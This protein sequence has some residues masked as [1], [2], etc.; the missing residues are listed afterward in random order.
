MNSIVSTISFYQ[1]IFNEYPEIIFPTNSSK[2]IIDEN[3]IDMR[4]LFKSINIKLKYV[5]SDEQC[6]FFKAVNT[7][8]RKK[9]FMVRV[10]IYTND[11]NDLLKSIIHKIK[12]LELFN[13]LVINK[14]TPHLPLLIA[15]FNTSIKNF[16]DLSDNKNKS[17]ENF[18]EKYH[19][20][21]YENIVTVCMDE[22]YDYNLLD[23]INDKCDS[24]SL[25]EWSVIFFQILHTLAIIHISYPNFMHGNLDVKNIWIQKIDSDKKSGTHYKYYINNSSFD[26]PNISLR[27]KICEL[28]EALFNNNNPEYSDVHY[29]FS[30]LK[31]VC[32]RHRRSIPPKV[33][34]FISRILQNDGTYLENEYICNVLSTDPLFKKMRN[35]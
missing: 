12:T 29:F 5:D 24:I 6:H 1:E 13:K 27:I 3:I 11:D 35:L 15:K 34:E 26:V 14:K 4:Q 10:Y 8:S 7:L 17:Y 16:I 32:A 9:I 31:N 22:L 19:K 20:N 33:F 2:S 25:K 30:T 23:Y 28:N 18:L 21:Q